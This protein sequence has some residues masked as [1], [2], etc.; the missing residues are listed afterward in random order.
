MPRER[1]GRIVAE[2]GFDATLTLLV[3]NEPAVAAEAAA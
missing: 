3:A 2:I 1:I